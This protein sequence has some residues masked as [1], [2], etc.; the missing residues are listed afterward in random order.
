[1]TLLADIKF[2]RKEGTHKTLS[3]VIL[4]LNGTVP[5]QVIGVEDLVGKLTMG[6]DEDSF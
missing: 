4:E 2:K 5:V 3:N 1:M 6:I